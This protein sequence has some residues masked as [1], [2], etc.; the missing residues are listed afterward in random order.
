MQSVLSLRGGQIK[1]LNSSMIPKN[2]FQTHKS[3]EYLRSN[4]E[5]FQAAYSWYK[6]EG[7]TYKFY[8]DNDCDN[9]MRTHYPS[10]YPLYKGLPLAV[11]R[12][13]LWRYCV[14]YKYGGIYADVDTILKCSPEMF[15]MDKDLVISAEHSDHLCQWVFAAPPGSPILKNIIDMVV[16]RISL[17]IHPEKHFVLN[18]TGP[19][20][21]TAAIIDYL[22]KNSH[23]VRPQNPSYSPLTLH[24]L[25]IKTI[26]VFDYNK[27]HTSQV[28]HLFYGC[29]DGWMKERNSYIRNKNKRDGFGLHVF[30]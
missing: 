13:D 29:R 23:L 22:R 5:L 3:L 9:F 27:F 12:A 28:E 21:F 10:I 4:P 6:N 2:I 20:V 19:G 26:H 1:M 14:I 15:I 24:S 16:H 30:S 7:Y 8:T 25:N 17:G 18:T 11:M